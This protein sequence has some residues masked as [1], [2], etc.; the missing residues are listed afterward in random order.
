MIYPYRREFCLYGGAGKGL[1]QFK[2]T[3][4]YLLPPFLIR[5]LPE[6]GMDISMMEACRLSMVH[7]TGESNSHI[8][9][10]AGT[11]LEK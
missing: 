3:E 2:D 10:Q 5:D 9:S 7:L 6:R 11:S 1:S 4:L 8:T